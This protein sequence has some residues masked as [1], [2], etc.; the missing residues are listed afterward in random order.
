MVNTRPMAIVRVSPAF[1]FFEFPFSISWWAH[2]TDTPEERRRIVLRRGMLMGLK[3]ETEVGGHLC[4]SSRVG[5]T[6]L[7]KNAQKKETKNRTSD[8][9]NKTIPVFSPFITSLG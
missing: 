6:L 9:I 3:D 5:E 8:R 7:W 2:V 1:E 4:P